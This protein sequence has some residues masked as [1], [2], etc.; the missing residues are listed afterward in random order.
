MDGLITHWHHPPVLACRVKSERVVESTVEQKVVGGDAKLPTG[1]VVA[2]VGSDDGIELHLK[3]KQAASE[4]SCIRSRIRMAAML[5]SWPAR[6]RRT[7]LARISCCS[8][9]QT[10]H[11]CTTTSLGRGGAPRPHRL[12]KTNVGH[13]CAARS[14]DCRCSGGRGPFLTVDAEPQV[15][16]DDPEHGPGVRLHGQGTS[17]PVQQRKQRRHIRQPASGPSVWTEDLRLH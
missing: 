8:S 3:A 4:R 2:A 1:A 6:G 11:R 14:R 9:C 5:P 15:E 13:R 17:L 16:G 7:R 12:Q 10:S